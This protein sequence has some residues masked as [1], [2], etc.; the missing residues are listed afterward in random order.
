MDLCVI[1]YFTSRL[2]A[3]S[4]HKKK[5][6]KTRIVGSVI[7]SIF[8]SLP[9][10][11]NSGTT[12][13]G[14]ARGFTNDCHNEPLSYGGEARRDRW[15]F[16]FDEGADQKKK[17]PRDRF[18]QGSGERG[19]HQYRRH[20]GG[21]RG[22]GNNFKDNSYRFGRLQQQR[23][24]DGEVGNGDA[25]EGEQPPQEQEGTQQG[26]F[27][28]GFYDRPRGRGNGRHFGGRRDDN[29]NERTFFK[30]ND[31]YKQQRPRR[32]YQFT[33]KY[34]DK[35]AEE[36][37]EAPQE[38]EQQPP[39]QEQQEQPQ[40]QEVQQRRWEPQR[41]QE[42]PYQ[43]PQNQKEHPRRH[44]Q[45]QQQWN[46]ERHANAEP[47]MEPISTN[48]NRTQRAPR[49]RKNCRNEREIELLF[50]RHHQQ[51]GISLENYASIPVD[52]VPRDIDPVESFEDL[53]VE[54]ALALNIAKCGY[55]EP[56]PVQ[57][58]GIPVCLNGNDLMAC[59]QTGSGKTAAF[60]IPVVHYILKHGVSPAKD[61][62]SHP[63]AVIMAPTRELALQIYDEVRKLTFRTDIFY[64]VVYG[65]T[66]YPSR[67]EN[68]IL[69]ACPGRLKDIFD[70]SNVSFSCV[71][72]LILDE[73]DRMLEM[74]FEDQI[75][76]LVASRYSDMPPS[77]DRQTLM[78]SAT[79]P[80]RILNLAKRYL[81]P[82]YYLLTVGRVGSTTKNITQRIQR[83][84]E[85]EKT[86]KLFEILYKQKQTDLV[87]IFVETKRSADYLQS[88]LNNNGIPST[89]IHGDRRQCD[90]ETAL[91][92]FKNGI[93]PIL[94]A[95]DIASRGLDIPNVAHVIQYDL[96]KEMDDYTHRIGRTGRAGNKGIATSFYDRNNRNLA[97][98]LYH[99]LRE[100][101]QEVPQWLENEKDAV[102]GER[103]LGVSRGGNRRL[104]GGGGG[105]R[106]PQPASHSTWGETASRR[107]GHN[108]QQGR[109]ESH[110]DDG[111]F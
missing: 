11:D 53:F 18:P 21:P 78:F 85:D 64:D 5:K 6:E 75:E 80:Q 86:D 111:G 110:I 97:V 105:N 102:E 76:Y 15:D 23:T 67:F 22:R 104:G 35:K 3:V 8:M 106:E 92:D 62:M 7:S 91:T 108:P 54:P 94:V 25:N 55:K 100:H 51:K 28:V 30:G 98:D 82:K 107:G 79:F 24:V 81:R 84:P 20:G 4:F 32:Q 45:N 26:R 39:K 77:D 9:Q 60:L 58:Y 38:H 87:L 99:Y 31:N 89:T 103:F 43:P 14:Q 101:D 33:P 109:K 48:P 36:H 42:R 57:R 93:K 63:I 73:A 56:T 96:P 69:V 34:E 70:R 65:G 16:R 29:G 52:I 83:V 1:V 44:Q 10:T 59:A 12:N 46:N 49:F 27:D 88:T 90:R 40:E 74:G 68:D 71:K 61:G 95:T 72:F 17:W 37:D 19:G 50:E 13:D 47:A 66:A 41:Q 2:N